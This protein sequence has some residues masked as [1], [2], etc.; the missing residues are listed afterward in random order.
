[1]SK[2]DQVSG[3]QDKLAASQSEIRSD[4]SLL[5]SQVEHVEGGITRVK[6]V[7]ELV[8]KKIDNV[9]SKVD[10]SSSMLQESYR[11]VLLLCRVVSNTIEKRESSSEEA[12]ML[13]D[14][15]EKCSLTANPTPLA[16]PNGCAEGRQSFSLRH[17][18]APRNPVP[19]VGLGSSYLKGVN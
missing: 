1:M 13:R 9:E 17:M 14:F 11:G 18:M 10:E 4:L 15:A 16:L 5:K 2:I 3:K 12:R 19:V 7:V 8:V 6:D